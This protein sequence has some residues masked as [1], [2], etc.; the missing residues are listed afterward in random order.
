MPGGIE[1]AR[2]PGRD[3]PRVR[4]W[5]ESEGYDAFTIIDGEA[6][7]R[8]YHRT[9]ATEGSLE[10]VKG[11][12]AS[13]VVLFL[14]VR[15]TRTALSTSTYTSTSTSSSSSSATTTSTTTTAAPLVLVLAGGTRGADREDDSGPDG[16]GRGGAKGPKLRGSRG[17]GG[18]GGRGGNFA[19]Q[20]CLQKDRAYW[21]M[22]L[23]GSLPVAAEDAAECEQRCT[24]LATCWHFSFFTKLGRCHLA[25]AGSVL[26][27]APADQ[28]VVAA[29]MACLS[30]LGDRD[31]VG[32]ARSSTRQAAVSS[33]TRR[34]VVSMAAAGCFGGFLIVLKF[35]FAGGS[36]GNSVGIGRSVWAE[37][38]A[39][40][41]CCGYRKL[42]PNNSVEVEGS[43]CPAG[44]PVY[45]EEFQNELDEAATLPLEAPR[46]PLTSP[47]QSDRS[48]GPLSS[49]RGAGAGT[50]CRW[51]QQGVKHVIPDE[52]R[53]EV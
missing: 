42:N 34:A 46:E 51:G 10:P 29:S 3:L 30:G 16:R 1:V 23:S 48:L 31:V 27:N 36:V 9:P 4:H 41:R 33:W 47:L 43:V 39:G 25:D 20:E 7:F 19:L 2:L 35:L 6:I 22:E 38:M 26:R 49:E 13:D 15:P 32:E 50:A 53:W 28:H 21:P 44:S 12:K 40:E 37:M 14:R 45:A 52:S 5:S 11:K 8:N 24:E 18:G 17:Y